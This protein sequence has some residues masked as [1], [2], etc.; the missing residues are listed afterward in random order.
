MCR[1]WEKKQGDD[2]AQDDPHSS[3]SLTRPIQSFVIVIV[4]PHPQ[5]RLKLLP[6]SLS[7]VHFSRNPS[8]S[9][10]LRSNDDCIPR[11]RRGIKSRFKI[12]C[13]FVEVFERRD[14]I[15]RHWTRFMS[16]DYSVFVTD[17]IDISNYTSNRIV[18]YRK[19]RARTLI[20]QFNSKIKWIPL[21]NLKLY[22]L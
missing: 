2:I 8:Q 17:L 21:A 14:M 16:E 11:L 18:A 10:R 22:F 19:I 9:V 1:T 4:G 20:A 15:Q 6:R 13:R 5:S 3:V 12:L 7:F